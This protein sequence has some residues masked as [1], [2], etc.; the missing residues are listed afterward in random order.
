MSRDGVAAH[1][2]AGALGIASFHRV[3]EVR[4][5]GAMCMHDLTDDARRFV[6]DCRIGAGLL[7][8]ASL[9]TTAG[10]LL[11]ECET[12]LRADFRACAEALVPRDRAYRHDDLTVRWENL[13]EEDAEAPNGH[14]HLQHALFGSPGLVVP[15]ADHRIVLG[16]WQRILL[17][18]Y[19]RSRARR[20]YFQALGIASSSQHVPVA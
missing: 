10:L 17:V 1:L 5:A 7:I 15:V 6:D 14:A 12:G 11:N 4:T 2:G 18:E 13:C 20:A 19:D 9:H 8:A 3:I 16:T